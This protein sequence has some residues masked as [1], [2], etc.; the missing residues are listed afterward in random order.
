MTLQHL[1]R[2]MSQPQIIQSSPPRIGE[3]MPPSNHVLPPARA[4]IS[5]GPIFPNMHPFPFMQF[6]SAHTILGLGPPPQ[7]QFKLVNNH[8]NSYITLTQRTHEEANFR[9]RENE[10]NGGPI[11]K[12]E[13]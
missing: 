10:E 12:E 13:P 1:T 4:T 5:P 2:Q 6:P 3:L 8:F 11:A 9:A 7:N